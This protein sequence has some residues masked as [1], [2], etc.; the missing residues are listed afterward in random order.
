MAQAD[1]VHIKAWWEETANKVPTSERRWLNGMMIYTFW[2]IWMEHNRRIFNNTSEMVLQ[3][4]ARIKDDMEQ[5]KR[6][7]AHT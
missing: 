5:R 4:A 1:L 3:V 7:F 6:V 2:N